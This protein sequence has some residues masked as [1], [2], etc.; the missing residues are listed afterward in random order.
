MSKKFFER[1]NELLPILLGQLNEQ[2]RREF[3]R[4]L[5][6]VTG[7]DCDVV[8]E[9]VTAHEFQRLAQLVYLRIKKGKHKAGPAEAE[10]AAYA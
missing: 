9:T 3:D 10:V 7:K 6:R 4:E 2:E 5:E 8:A 1:M